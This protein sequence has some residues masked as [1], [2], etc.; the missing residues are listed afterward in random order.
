MLQFTLSNSW[1]I[2]LHDT[3]VRS[4]CQD[5]RAHATIRRSPHASSISRERLQSGLVHMSVM[6][7]QLCSPP[8]I[9]HIHPC[10]V[11]HT[12]PHHRLASS[13]STTSVS[14]TSRV[15]ASLSERHTSSNSWFS[16]ESADE[17]LPLW[18]SLDRGGDCSRSVRIVSSRTLGAGSY[19]RCQR[20]DQHLLQHRYQ[21]PSTSALSP[22]RPSY[23]HTF[24]ILSS[25]PMLLTSYPPPFRPPR[26]HI[27]TQLPDV[28]E[29]LR[30][31]EG[32]NTARGLGHVHSE[33]GRT[34]ERQGELSGQEQACGERRHLQRHLRARG[35]WQ[36]RLRR[37]GRG[38]RGTEEDNEPDVHSVR[39]IGRTDTGNRDEGA[40]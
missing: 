16:C 34:N 37:T 9:F 33:D 15:L 6:D 11:L 21:P 8:G 40:W 22:P 5:G 35:S 1:E 38:R 26:A 17:D 39:R 36:P 24:D 4:E 31:D 30:R 23:L 25:H 27:L 28:K 32:H 18:K 13:P 19:F 2:S 3:F 29:A 10:R 14:S 7:E 20:Q 12:P